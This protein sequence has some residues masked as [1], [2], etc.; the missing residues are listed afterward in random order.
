E[1]SATPL[2]V[3]TR[4]GTQQE[5][6]LFYRGVSVFSVPLSAQAMADSKVL[7]KNH[8]KDEVPGV[9][10]FERR[11]DRLGYRMGGALRDEVTLDPPELNSTVESL[12]HDLE[13]VL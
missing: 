9:I 8:G 5:K 12:S 2:M 7:I 13:G 10:L 1:T 3:R 11:G 6:F 4:R